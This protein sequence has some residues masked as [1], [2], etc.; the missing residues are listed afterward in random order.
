[1]ALTAVSAHTADHRGFGGISLSV[2]RAESVAILGLDAAGKSLFCRILSG[3]EP[4]S[5]GSLRV[6]GC[7]I[8]APPDSRDHPC[9]DVG[10]VE[11]S[12]DLPARLSVMD[13]VT[14]AQVRTRGMSPILA[15]ERA[16]ALLARVEML[17]EARTVA[18]KLSNDQRRRV[19]IAR[20][21]AL[22]PR[23]LVMEDP[24]RDL[25]PSTGRLIAD[26]VREA[27]REGTAVVLAT[28]DL[29]LVREAASRIIVVCAGRIVE[30]QPAADFFL[31]P[32]TPQ[33]RDILARL[34]RADVVPDAVPD[35]V[36]EAVP[37][38]AEG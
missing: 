1:M 14:R 38:V 28:D 4:I 18:G 9:R 33:A 17:A 21:L 25:G 27:T 13:N 31:R 30:D 3:D 6:G 7:E 16:R 20:A 32:G 8:P 35:V 34:S 37:G 26:L 29:T 10:L 24:T 23:L 11:S 22:T 5:S 2:H 36:P 19:Q 12:G 15:T